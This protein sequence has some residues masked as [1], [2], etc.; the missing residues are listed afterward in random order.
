MVI[1]NAVQSLPSPQK[2]IP[3]KTHSPSAPSPQPLATT[4]VLSGHL[5][6]LVLATSHKWNCVTCSLW[7]FYY[8][9]R[10]HSRG[11]PV[12]WAV[13]LS[14]KPG[15]CS[16]ES[17]SLARAGGQAGDPNCGQHISLS[18]PTCSPHCPSIQLLFARA[19]S[20]RGHEG[21]SGVSHPLTMW[22][23]QVLSHSVPQF[24]AW[25]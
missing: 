19:R 1:H 24:P 23:G 11:S 2:K 18:C 5:D 21:G 15:A 22:P 25:A 4:S 10:C 3:L 14:H 12:T 17:L 16:S 8:C 9:F 20:W 13:V 7:P 6:L